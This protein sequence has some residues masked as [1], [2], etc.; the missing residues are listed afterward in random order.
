MFQGNRCNL[1]LIG[2]RTSEAF[3]QVYIAMQFPMVRQIKQ[4]NH[5]CSNFDNTITTSYRNNHINTVQSFIFGTTL[6]R[7]YCR[8]AIIIW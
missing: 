5:F 8:E 4:C 3:R 1:P 7:T 2:R 6:F